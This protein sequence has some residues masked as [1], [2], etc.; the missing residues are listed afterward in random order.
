MYQCNILKKSKFMIFKKSPISRRQAWRA[1]NP[2]R[3]S[4]TEKTG[5]LVSFLLIFTD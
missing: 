3:K 1:A 5:R 4:N 2:M